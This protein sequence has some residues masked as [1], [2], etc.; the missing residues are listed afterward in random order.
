[1]LP[2]TYA[3]S[4]NRKLQENLGI[5]LGGLQP[6]VDMNFSEDARLMLEISFTKRY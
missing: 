6:E 2:F 3:S 4:Y 5:T 1:M